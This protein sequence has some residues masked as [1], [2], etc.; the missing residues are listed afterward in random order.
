M[1]VEIFFA[2]ALKG[3]ALAGMLAIAYP[4]K[5]AVERMPDCR[6]KRLLLFRWD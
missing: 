2:M 1:G 4:I 5:K 3:F 6:L